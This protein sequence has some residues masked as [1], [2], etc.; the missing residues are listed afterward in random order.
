[1][2]FRIAWPLSSCNADWSAL[3]MD[4]HLDSL[5]TDRS[6]LSWHTLCIVNGDGDTHG[7]A[8]NDAVCMVAPPPSIGCINSNWCNIFFSEINSSGLWILCKYQSKAFIQLLLWLVAALCVWAKFNIRSSVIED[9]LW[10]FNTDKSNYKKGSGHSTCRVARLKIIQI[11]NWT[12]RQLRMTQLL[13]SKNSKPNMD[14]S[15]LY[16]QEVLEL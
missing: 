1:M 6:T 9:F 16:P 3:V 4:M 8:K 11:D 7:I 13:I 5:V 2:N 15:R 10:Q 12:Y 14:S